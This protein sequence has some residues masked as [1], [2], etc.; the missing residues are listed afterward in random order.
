MLE[1]NFIRVMLLN[2]AYVDRI[3][4]YERV[5]VTPSA[6]RI[7]SA[8]TAVCAADE[9]VDMQ[10]L[11]DALDR[12]DRAL[13][14][15]IY[16]KIQLADKEEAV[17]AECADAVKLS[18]LTGR[19][20][21]IIRMLTVANDVENEERIEALTRELIDIQREIEEVKGR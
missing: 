19:E 9:D 5:F 13:L 1:R 8:I 20:N 17:F 11:E 3:K 4:P 6:F 21:E 14:W 18:A 7:Y 2:G 10:K 12:S 16:E 15:D